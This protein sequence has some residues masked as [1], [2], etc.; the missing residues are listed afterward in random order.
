MVLLI[1]FNRFFFFSVRIFFPFEWLKTLLL[2]F[3]H[4]LYFSSFIFF[5]DVPFD[6][7]L[8]TANELVSFSFGWRAFCLAF[9]SFGSYSLIF[10]LC[11]FCYSLEQT[12]HCFFFIVFFFWVSKAL[13]HLRFSHQ[14]FLKVRE[15]ITWVL[16][17]RESE[18]YVQLCVSIDIL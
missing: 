2:A 8:F 6:F 14:R 12:Y 13:R 11:C 1:Y 9:K 4:Y 7:V 3:L 5:L 15:M 18:F 16:I 17:V 10:T